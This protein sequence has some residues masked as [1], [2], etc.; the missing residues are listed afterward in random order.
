MTEV[1]KEFE[2]HMNPPEEYIPTQDDINMIITIKSI[3]KEGNNA[4]VKL[5]RGRV[6]V[7]ADK[8][9]ERFLAR[10]MFSW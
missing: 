1:I 2:Q 7:M 3:L 6:A 4:M 9:K 8:P 10:E 5:K